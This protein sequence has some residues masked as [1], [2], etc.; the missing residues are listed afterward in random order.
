MQKRACGVAQVVEFLFR[1][2][3]ALSF[4]SVL[5]KKKKKKSWLSTIQMYIKIKGG[6]DECMGGNLQF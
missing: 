3:E 5:T 1:K 4:L 6:L 2:Q